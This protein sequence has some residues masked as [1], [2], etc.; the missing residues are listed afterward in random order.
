MHGHNFDAFIES[1]NESDM[2]LS[3]I[4]GEEITKNL[5]YHT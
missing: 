5:A 4:Y 2:K 1:I 3:R